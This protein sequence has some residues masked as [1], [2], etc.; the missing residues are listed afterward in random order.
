MRPPMLKPDN[1]QRFLSSGHRILGLDRVFLVGQATVK[2]AA[3]P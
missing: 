2:E 1:R 3:A